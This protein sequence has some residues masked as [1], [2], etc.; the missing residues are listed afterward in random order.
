MESFVDDSVEWSRYRAAVLDPLEF[1]LRET[2]NDELSEEQAATLRE[3]YEQFLR[4]ALAT[5][6]TVT[7]ETGPRTIR[8]RSTVTEVDTTSLVVN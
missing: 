1:D 4:E 2:S 3:Y 5:H 6:W 7:N 8:V